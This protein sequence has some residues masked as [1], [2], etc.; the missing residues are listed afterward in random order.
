[1]HIGNPKAIMSWMAI[2]SLGLREDAPVGTL[3]AIIGGCALLGVI[4]FGGYAI[5]FSTARMIA[6]Y[7]RL[8]RWIQG[9]FCALFALA[10]L[11][12]LV[13]SH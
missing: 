8:R 5:V 12:L 7:T 11:K 1:M 9:L 13:S 4:I 2:M 3:P 10:G 6:G